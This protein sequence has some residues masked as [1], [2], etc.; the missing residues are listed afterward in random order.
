MFYGKNFRGGCV[1]GLNLN[2]NRSMQTVSKGQTFHMPAYGPRDGRK[3][4]S[5][6]A[7]LYRFH[8]D[9]IVSGA[10]MV[11]WRGNAVAVL[12]AACLYFLQATV[13]A[14]KYLPQR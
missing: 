7:K 4:S 2:S 12:G 1:A 5:A 14:G 6:M 3:S 11:Q 10:E 9:V 8:K 13:F